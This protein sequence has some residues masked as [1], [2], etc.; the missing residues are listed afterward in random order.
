[1]VVQYSTCNT[2]NT[3]LD[4]ETNNQY[5]NRDIRGVRDPGCRASRVSRINQRIRECW[6]YSSNDVVFERRASN[7]MCLCKASRQR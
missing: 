1:M 6:T 2:C 5:V 4:F 7:A 3:S